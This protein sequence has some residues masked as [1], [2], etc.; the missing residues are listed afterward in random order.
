MVEAER[1][2]VL[3]QH[4]QGYITDAELSLKMRGIT[5]RLEH[6]TSEVSQLALERDDSADILKGLDNFLQTTHQIVERID[7][8]DDA[9]RADRLPIGL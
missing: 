6:L 9:E 7:T 2:R 1:G 3:M 5:E 4:Q 8:M